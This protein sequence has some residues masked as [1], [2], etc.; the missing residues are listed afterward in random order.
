LSYENF[1]SQ[2]I[3][4]TGFFGALTFTAMVLI[5][6]FSSIIM[7]SEIL[8]PWTAI[9]S[10]FFIL[11]TIGIINADAE[12]KHPER[13]R[14]VIM[15]S[16]MVGFYGLIFVIP[17]LVYTFTIIGA[18]IIFVIEVTFLVIFN[19]SLASPLKSK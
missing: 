14:R 12:K 2:A 13:F 19:S 8:I 18:V 6:Q 3:T 16:F 1:D 5:M 9:V 10:F 17:A 7:F 15:F 4:I 11:T